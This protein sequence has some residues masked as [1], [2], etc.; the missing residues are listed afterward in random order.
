MK[1]LVIGSIDEQ[2][3]QKAEEQRRFQLACEA[4]GKELAQAGHEIVVGQEASDKAGMY[5]IQGAA[6]ANLAAGIKT[7]VWLLKPGDSTSVQIVTDRGASNIEFLVK[8]IPVANYEASR[9]F[10]ADFVDAVIA[11]SGSSGTAA[12][13]QIAAALGKVVLGL[14]GLG[15]SGKELWDQT[16]TNRASAGELENQYSALEVEWPTFA[17]TDTE[18]KK[19]A[20]K[21]ATAK[22]AKVVVEVIEGL[23]KFGAFKSDKSGSVVF[24]YTILTWVILLLL[25][26][27]ILF[28]LNSSRFQE[29]AKQQNSLD[30]TVSGGSATSS[31][32]NVRP[33]ARANNTAE[34]KKATSDDQSKG[35]PP[36]LTSNEQ[37]KKEDKGDKSEIRDKTEP[38]SDSKLKPDEASKLKSDESKEGAKKPQDNSP[39]PQGA[40]ASPPGEAWTLS[41]FSISPQ[42]SIWLFLMA[43]IATGLGVF[44]RHSLRNVFD[45][46]AHT[47][48]L[49]IFTDA[50]SGLILT[51]I[52]CLLYIV[53]AVAFTG[54]SEHALSPER[55]NDFQRTAI[56]LSLVGVTCGFLVEQ[57][58]ESLRTVLLDRFTKFKVR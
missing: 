33:N 23:A 52:V 5:V 20:A 12:C 42:S 38:N 4:I 28:S 17:D 41:S 24:Q 34:G 54:T 27:A 37:A 15:G 47:A 25:S 6:A 57:T 44:L 2:K 21:E 22:L 36:D 55:L 56:T 53:G 40:D 18:E 13:G 26:W 43:Y 16:A 45:S 8:R 10:M 7:R 49:R 31:E 3:Q 58:A 32:N 46:T 19:N 29:L 14:P 11:I 9:Y 1:V 48:L 39:N 30:A 35:T 51:F 50:A